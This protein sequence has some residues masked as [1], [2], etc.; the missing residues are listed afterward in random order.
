MFAV[1]MILFGFSFSTTDFSFVNLNYL[2]F[3][4]SLIYSNAL[5]MLYIHAVP[6]RSVATFDA[7]CNLLHSNHLALLSI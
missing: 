3:Y 7:T 1:N 5:K 6:R 2:R 4:T